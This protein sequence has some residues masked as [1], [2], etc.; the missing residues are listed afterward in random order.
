MRCNLNYRFKQ[1]EKIDST[2]W[3]VYILKCSDDSLY[4]GITNNLERRT[5]EHNNGV[6][7]KYTKGRTPV[8][9]VY[10]EN[11][12]NRSQA[13]KRELEIKKLCRND[14]LRLIQR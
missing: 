8:E 3:T 6:G 5:N 7:A 2:L 12:P 14:K 9:V 11:C 10:T 4:T 13:S 1:M